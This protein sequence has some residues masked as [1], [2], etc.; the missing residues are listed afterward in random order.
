MK[1]IHC[2]RRFTQSHWGGTETCI[3]NLARAQRGAG[4][5]ARIFTSKALCATPDEEVQ[6]VPVRRFNYQYPFLNLSDQSRQAFD[7]SGGNL[8]SM[9]LFGALCQ[10]KNVTL[11]HAHSGKRLGAVVRT[12]AHLRGIPYVISL[13]GGQADIPD[14]ITVAR[15]GLRR[16]SFEWGKVAGAVLGAR[17]VLDDA[18]AIFC[19]GRNVQDK[20]QQRYPEKQVEYV[21]NGV[22]VAHF[23]RPVQNNFRARH[24]IPANAEVMLNVGRI[25]P[26][27]N[28]LLLI[29]TLSKLT[30]IR[31]NLHLLL[32]GHITDEDYAATLRAAIKRLDL[33]SRVT[34][35]PGLPADSA[36]LVAAYQSSNLFCLPS[37]H[38][39]FG[40][41]ILEAWAAGLPVITSNVGGI[42]GFT[43]DGENVLLADN[44][45]TVTWAS[46]IL[47]CLKS[48]QLVDNL[49][50]HAF[51]EVVSHYD[52]PIIN[53]RVT[54]I[55]NHLTQERR[56]YA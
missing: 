41:A 16:G 43:R 7:L 29:E 55:Y 20:M 3:L 52:W 33:A 37:I 48:P 35:L 1:V 4:I 46:L 9:R 50:E 26:Q 51:K 53:A 12:A 13:H 14:V 56:R 54:D 21:P 19:V 40:I 39:P 22:D 38:E 44:F 28:Q 5:D 47:G 27:K 17:R 25:D 42:S 2:P 10:E 11:L 45:D 18:A 36:D 15:D 8:L 34:L 32:I 24:G 30:G 49:I 6:S 23:S 31:P